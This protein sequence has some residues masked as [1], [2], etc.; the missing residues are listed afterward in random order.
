MRQLWRDTR[1][2]SSAVGMLLVVVIIGI[3]ATV[4]LST[5]RD[6]VV[7]E[8]GDVAVGLNHLDQS[9]NYEISVDANGDGDLNDPQD[10]V[11]TG[12]YI[13]VGVGDLSDPAGAAP[14]C[15]IIN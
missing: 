2:E 1:A 10:K 5:M 6:Q 11:I 4:G 12:Q 7:Q 8:L 14:A 13:D 9:F 15:L 3:G